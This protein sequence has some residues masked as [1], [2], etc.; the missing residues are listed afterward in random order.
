MPHV[1]LF[2]EILEYPTK[3]A[4]FSHSVLSAYDQVCCYM[5]FPVVVRH[6]FASAVAGECGL[7][8]HQCER[9][10]NLEQVY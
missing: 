2:L 4:L 5:A 8:F 3:Y 6:Y 7:N 1:K 9:T 10:G